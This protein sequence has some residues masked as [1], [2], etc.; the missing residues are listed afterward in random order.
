[1]KQEINLYLEQFRPKPIPFPAKRVFGIAALCLVVI[2]AATAAQWYHTQTLATQQQHWQEQRAAAEQ[3][4]AEY[5]KLYPAPITDKGLAG[6]INMMGN[7]TIYQ[8]RLLAELEIARDH[9]SRFSQKLAAIA[10]QTVPN[11]WLTNIYF[12]DAGVQL[13]LQGKTSQTSQPPVLLSALSREAVLQG[14]RFD[15]FR[16]QQDETNPKV[17]L[18]RVGTPR[19]S[20]LTTVAAPEIPAIPQLGVRP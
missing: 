2:L 5:T 8:E 18:F 1:M 16:M 12:Y 9:Q 6:R 17:T 14:Y 20:S 4:V 3:K 19:T 11:V 10:R 13:A 15:N 7:T